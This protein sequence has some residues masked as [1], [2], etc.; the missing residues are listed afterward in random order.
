MACPAA[1]THP[2]ACVYRNAPLHVDDGHLTLGL[3]GVLVQEFVEG[4]LW[5]HAGPQQAQ[6]FVAVHRAG[7]GLGRDGAHAGFDP[8]HHPAGGEVARLYSYSQLGSGWIPG[9]DRVGH[10]ILFPQVPGFPL[11]HSPW[12]PC[13]GRPP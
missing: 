1:A 4:S 8:R 2:R 13:L 6:S 11:P 10:T 5:R 7:K 3:A 12:G 9:N